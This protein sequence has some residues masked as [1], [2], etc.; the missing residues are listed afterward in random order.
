MVLPGNLLLLFLR[1]GLPL[2]PGQSIRQAVLQRFHQMA[3]F[4]PVHLQPGPERLHGCGILRIVH[5]IQQLLVALLHLP[6]AF[7]P[8]RQLLRGHTGSTAGIPHGEFGL[9]LE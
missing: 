2:F 5:G 6:Q 7:Q 9:L 3:H 1:Q 8:V 4:R